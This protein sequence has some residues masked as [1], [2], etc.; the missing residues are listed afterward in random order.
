MLLPP[1]SDDISAYKFTPIAR[2]EALEW[3]PQWSP[4]GKS[5]AYSLRI[6]GIYQIF[7]KTIGSRDAAQLTKST[8]SCVGIFWSPDGSI[9]YYTTDTGL[10]TVGASGGNPNLELE[11]VNAAAIHPDGKTFVFVRDGKLWVGPLRGQ[12]RPFGQSPFP[13]RIVDAAVLRFSPDGAKL[14]VMNRGE[15]AAESDVWLIA[16]PSGASR[17]LV[18]A[19]DLTRPSWMPDSRRILFNSSTNTLSLVDT[20]T[21]ACG[22]CTIAP[23]LCCQARSHQTGHGS[24][25]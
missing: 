18:R 21:G 14:A 7:T 3:E 17:K 25:M 23:L 24:L 6:H 20:P 9:I 11:K 13:A 22:S 16:Y 8:E 2:E 10:W 15:D 19:F 5:I 4:D 12:A 1:P